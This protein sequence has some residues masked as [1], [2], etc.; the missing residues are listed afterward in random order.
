M[1]GV[2][3]WIMHPIDSTQA[4]WEDAVV[5][6]KAAVNDFDNAI[7]LHW[8]NY[9][10][11]VALG[12]LAEWQAQLNRATTVQNAIQELQDQLQ[13]ASNWYKQTFGNMN[14]LA[15][16]EI[17]LIPIA[18]ITGSISAVVAITYAIYSYNQQLDQKWNYIQAN[19]VPPEQVQNILDSQGGSMLP[20]ISQSI[21]S[22]GNVA[23]WIVIGGII[24]KFGPALFQEF[25]KG[26][27]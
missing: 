23:L 14:G 2:L 8:D 1:D 21:S 18:V 11:A 26:G 22:I 25:K 13:N 7:Q 9:D 10:K 15:G 4:A 17:A 6:W 16:P 12:D 24:L 19:N 5:R 27:K 3:D 20:G